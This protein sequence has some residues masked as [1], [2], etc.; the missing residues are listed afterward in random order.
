ML[1]I[2]VIACSGGGKTPGGGSGNGGGQTDCQ[3]GQAADYFPYH[4][5]AV[6]TYAGQGNEF[7]A[8]K[9]K[10]VGEGGGKV[11]W[12]RDTGGTVM[13]EVYQVAPQQV[14]LIYRE[15]EA[16]DNTPRLNNPPN[17]AEPV[18]KGPI[19]AG[20]Q[21]TAGQ[22]TYKIT[23]INASVQALGNQTLTCVVE[24]EVQFPNSLIKNY[25]HKQYGLVYTVFNPGSDQISSRLATFTP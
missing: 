13:A 6:A 12:R 7:A 2:S 3:P 10:V 9:V 21:W 24:V 14:T 8:F 17:Q 20:A 22:N 23:N 19:Q 16:Y 1:G 4:Q 11:E 18:L 25:W 15:G 5:G